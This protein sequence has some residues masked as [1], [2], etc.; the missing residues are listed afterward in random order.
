[1]VQV[2][3]TEEFTQWYASLTDAERDS[4]TFVVGLLRAAGVALGT[5]YSSALEGTEYA[6]RELRP[7]HGRSPLRVVY[8]F[9]PYRDAVLIIGG[10]KGGDSKFYKRIIKAAENIWKEYLASVHAAR[11]KEKKP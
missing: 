5:P 9:D 1:M 11:G 8:A 3:A 6:L 7:K 10:S 4:V 2:V